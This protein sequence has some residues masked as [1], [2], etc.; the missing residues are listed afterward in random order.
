MSQDN[1]IDKCFAMMKNFKKKTQDV[2]Y[3]WNYFDNRVLSKEWW[4]AQKILFMYTVTFIRKLCNR[5][6]MKKMEWSS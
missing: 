3:Q 1:N 4:N 5:N 6:P 2:A